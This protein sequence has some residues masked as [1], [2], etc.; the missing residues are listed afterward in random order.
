MPMDN[1]INTMQAFIVTE[2]EV[3]DLVGRLDSDTAP[4][5]EEDAMLCIKSGA[6]EMVLDC[7]SLSVMTGAGI[8]TI[9]RLARAMQMA[10][11]KLAICNPQ[12]PVRAMIEACGI[13]NFIAVY[14]DQATAKIAIAA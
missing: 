1:A 5:I 7:A 6:Q 11:G 10:R 8:R 13:D 4:I 14:D 12:A 2:P 3:M 9:L